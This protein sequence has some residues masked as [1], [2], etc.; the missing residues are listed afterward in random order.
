MKSIFFS[1]LLICVL[2]FFSAGTLIAQKTEHKK[3]VSGTTAIKT[4]DNGIKLNIKG[5]K[6]KEATLYF[7]DDTKV[8][9][10]NKVDLNQR[11]NMLIII[12]SGWTVEN[13]KVY[14]GGSELIKLNTGAEV[15]KS[16]DLFKD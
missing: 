6:V 10:D 5:F 11:I 7:D 8:P 13:E 15:L 1:S 16:D 4:F 12:D 9:A 2:S 3:P 14:L